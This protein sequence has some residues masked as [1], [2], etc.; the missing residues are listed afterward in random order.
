M[1]ST[2]ELVEER[3]RDWVLRLE[4]LRKQ[5]NYGE[6]IVAWNSS[7]NASANG[8]NGDYDV[9]PFSGEIVFM[10]GET[11]KTINLTIIADN[12]PEANEVFQVR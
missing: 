8:R 9:Y 11:R 7:G 5:G 2:Y 3:M 6:V 10:Q 4:V 1:A 12:I